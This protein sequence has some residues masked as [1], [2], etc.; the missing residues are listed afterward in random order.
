M[1]EIREKVMVMKIVMLKML[2]MKEKIKIL[3]FVNVE[4]SIILKF[5][6]KL[7]QVSFKEVDSTLDLFIFWY[8]TDCLLILRIMF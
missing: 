4:E 2:R 8:P 1:V 7:A 6:A 5:F 3:C